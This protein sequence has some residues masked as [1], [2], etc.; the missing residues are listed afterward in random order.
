MKNPVSRTYD[1]LA[2]EGG[3]T[4]DPVQ[5]ELACRLDALLG[6][7]ADERTK[8]KK[9]PLGWLFSKGRRPEP[10]PGL[11][12]WGPVG[13]GKTMLM[14]IFFQAAPNTR[15]RR[16]HFHDFMED[17]HE[18]IARFRQRLKAGEVDGDDPIKPVA[19]DIA[20]ETRLLCFDEF[21]VNDIADAMILGRLFEK[22]FAEGVTLVATSNVPPDRLYENGLNRP[23]FV[24]FIDLINKSNAVFHLDA[25]H[26]Y[27]LDK[28]GE[29]PLYVTPLGEAAEKILDAHFERLSGEARG[30][31]QQLSLRGR[32]LD[33]P[34]AAGGVARFSFHELCEKPLGSADYLKLAKTFHTIIVSG[35]PVMSPQT[36]NEAKRFINLIDTLYDQ[37]IRFIA[38]AEA[39]PDALW[40]GTSGAEA[41][42]FQRTASRLTEMRS[43]AWPGEAAERG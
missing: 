27:R 43:D 25:P 19:R 42:E 17:V 31:P 10:V 13:R 28:H 30:T 5:K 35:I 7:L 4:P 8:S 39:E 22:L 18:R 34:E 24:P 26:D 3:I 1:R 16:A 40:Q 38:S 37:K 12:I 15:K 21:A 2:A 20:A 41:F 33:V 6:A 29:E 32:H 14:D 11:Y 23:L 36:R 9:S